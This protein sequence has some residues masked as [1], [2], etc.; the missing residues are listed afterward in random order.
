MTQT[1]LETLSLFLRIVTRKSVLCP[2][3]W[4]VINLSPGSWIVHTAAGKRR[5]LILQLVQTG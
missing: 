2:Y 4:H 5:V 3:L 1:T